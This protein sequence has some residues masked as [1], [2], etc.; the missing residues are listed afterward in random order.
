MA[1]DNDEPRI[2][3][4]LA[5]AQ[6]SSVVDAETRRELERW[7]Q[8][9]VVA[10]PEPAPEPVDEQLKALLERRDRAIAAIDPS[11]VKAIEHRYEIAPESLIK[12][13]VLLEVEVRD[14][15]P[16]F[17]YAMIDRLS[18]IAEPREYQ[19]S[20]ELSDELRET[21]PQAL[22]RDLHRL[23]NEFVPS[24]DITDIAADQRL[25]IVAAVDDAMA[26]NWALPPLGAS[27]FEQERC[28]LEQDR[29]AIYRNPWIEIRMP[30]RT[31]TE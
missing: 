25:D 6:L 19:R 4:L 17:D 29:K 5:G 15:M 27:P 24:F 10:T 31:I 22:L 26:T 11:L 30:N 2:R 3:E 12:F 20:D 21:S 8:S 23:E 13:Q 14:D 9:G 18:T 1:S 16:L 28:L 7:L